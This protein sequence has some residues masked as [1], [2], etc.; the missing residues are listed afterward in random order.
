MSD[1]LRAASRRLWAGL[2]A[3]KPLLDQP[4]PDDPR[5]TPW[6]RFV[7][8]RLADLQSEVAK[9]CTEQETTK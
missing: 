9:T 7:E 5:W 6:T 4:Y 2:M 1:D 3:V 8:P